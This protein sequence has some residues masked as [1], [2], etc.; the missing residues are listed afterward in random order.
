MA[1]QWT[2]DFLRMT[3]GRFFRKLSTQYLV[4]FLIATS[5]L[6]A[7]D[8]LRFQLEQTLPISAENFTTDKLQNVYILTPQKEVV[9]FNAKGQETFRYS[10][11]YLDEL[12][13][14]DAT[15][16]FNLLLY[17][18]DYQTIITLDRTLSETARFE[19]LD[20]QFFRVPAVAMASDNNIWLY[21][22]EQFKL[23]KIKNNGE[24]IAESDD[25]SLL[26]SATPNPTFLVEREQQVFVNAP[27]IGILVF[28]IFGQYMQTIPITN[29][30]AFQVLENQL[31]F[32]ENG[33]LK[34][35]HLR[36]L[37]TTNIALPG[38][39]HLAKKI[40][41]RKGKM[42]VLMEEKVFVFALKAP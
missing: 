11:T 27:D 21:D 8:S 22:S 16:P 12:P 37:L 28:D 20:L 35:Y 31:L 42:Y 23:K 14:M 4:L 7:Q 29:L 25:L 13:E 41:L 17:Y 36:S 3:M 24:V 32:R 9:K 19:L 10:N 33:Q 38:S 15:D 26:L 34:S 18:P 2:Y 40:M 5:P 39:T 1:K 30:D 6:F